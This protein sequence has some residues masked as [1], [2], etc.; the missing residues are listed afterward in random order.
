MGAHKILFMDLLR[1]ITPEEINELTTKH[2]GEIRFSLT[3][4]LEA[5]LAGRVFDP[6]QGERPPADILPFPAATSDQKPSEDVAEASAAE[7]GL[8]LEKE[9]T[10]CFILSEKKRFEKNQKILKAREVLQLYSKEASV[11]VD[12]RKKSKNDDLRKSGDVGLLVD[13]KHY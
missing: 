9:N 10:S 1:I 7:E 4:M 5:Q 12:F 6:Q 2:E 11:N 3:E 8:D 13:K